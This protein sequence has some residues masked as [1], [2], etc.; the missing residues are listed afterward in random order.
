MILRHFTG[1][2]VFTVFAF[3][4]GLPTLFGYGRT[5]GVFQPEPTAPPTQAN[6]RFP[7]TQADL[8][9]FTGNVA[10]PN[11]MVWLND[12]IYV[13]CAGDQSVYKLYGTSGATDTYIFGVT[14]AYA[15]YAKEQSNGAVHLWVPDPEK[16]SLLR[17]TPVDVQVVASG[18]F[19]PW[20]IT[21]LSSTL[22]LVTIHLSNQVN[23]ITQTGERRTLISGLAKPTGIDTDGEFVYVANSGDPERAL[24]WYALEAIFDDETAAHTL[25]RGLTNVLNVRIGPDGKLYFIYEENDQGVIGRV[26]PAE[27][28]V[29]GGCMADMVER[30]IVTDLDA[31]LAGL[32]FAPDGRLFFHERYGETLYWAQIIT[33]PQ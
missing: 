24:E 16:G 15:L 11:G 3:T 31:P 26:D 21:A 7:L 13:V 1:V 32:T 30:V 9:S 5:G 22:F 12:E 8:V 19:E 25:V 14:D 17:V 20:G 2:V 29:D 10:R 33:A 28:R 27:C 6:E 23:I 4:L 18:M